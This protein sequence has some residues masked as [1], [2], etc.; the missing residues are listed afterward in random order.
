MQVN[1]E[2]T[3]K[4][5]DSKFKIEKYFLKFRFFSN[6]E[7]AILNLQWMCLPSASKQPAISIALRRGSVCSKLLVNFT[8]MPQSELRF[9]GTGTSS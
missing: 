5:A 2:N 6:L 4:I 7:S 3:F 8:H 9:L 1:S